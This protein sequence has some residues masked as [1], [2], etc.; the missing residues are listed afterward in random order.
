MSFSSNLIA[1]ARRLLLAYGENLTFGR[2]INGIYNP[3]D[4]SVSTL[5]STTYTAYCAPM[6]FNKNEIDGTVIKKHDVKLIMEKPT[7]AVPT[8]GDTVTLN[9]VKMRVINVEKVRAQ[10]SD[11]IYILQVRV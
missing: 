1:V 5:L 2:D 3:L 8:V 9:S 7:S 4:G 11:I 6:E 10:G